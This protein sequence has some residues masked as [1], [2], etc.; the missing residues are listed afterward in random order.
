MFLALIFVAIARNMERIGMHTVMEIEEKIRRR[1]HQPKGVEQFGIE[2]VPPEL[3]T[4][5]LYTSDAA[6]E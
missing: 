4:C 3:K 5:L 6:D 1:Y 2:P